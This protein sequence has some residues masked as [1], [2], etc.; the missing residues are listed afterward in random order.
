M[1]TDA[2]RFAGPAVIRV[3][4]G[5]LSR[6]GRVL[7]CQRKRGGAFPLKWEFPG[8]KLREGET[9]ESALRRELGE[10][11]AITIPPEGARKLEV[12]RH[13]YPE[14]TDVELHFFA[15]SSFAGE[16]VNL[17]FETISWVET[18]GIGAYDFLE[19]DRPLVERIAAGWDL[20]AD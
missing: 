6:D 14:G 9:A 8:G 10:E 20:R 19:A 16:P 2:L 13:R 15:V 12:V 11:L 3:A 17:C 1:G 18:A 4:A 7:V 5:I